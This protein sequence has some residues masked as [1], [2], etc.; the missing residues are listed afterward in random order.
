MVL[1]ETQ[2]SP[3]E[4]IQS[5]ALAYQHFSLI[6]LTQGSLKSKC[7]C[8]RTGEIIIGIEQKPP[9]KGTK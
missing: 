2:E 9:D 7:K 5:L 6:L 3:S 8:Q 4:S 1:A